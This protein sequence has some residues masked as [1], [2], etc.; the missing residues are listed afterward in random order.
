MTPTRQRRPP[1]RSAAFPF[2][3]SHCCLDLVHFTAARR[4][5]HAVPL[6]QDRKSKKPVSRN[7]D[8]PW[9]QDDNTP[10]T[11]AASTKPTVCVAA[12]RPDSST[13]QNRAPP[14]LSHS[15]NNFS[16]ERAHAPAYAAVAAA[17]LP[18]RAAKACARALHQAAGGNAEASAK[19]AQVAAILG[20]VLGAGASPIRSI[21]RSFSAHPHICTP[22]LSRCPWWRAWRPLTQPLR[23]LASPRENSCSSSIPNGSARFSR[24]RTYP[25]QGGFLRKYRRALCTIAAAKFSSHKPHSPHCRE[26]AR[27]QKRSR[28]KSR[29]R[30]RLAATAYLTD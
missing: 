19:A 10:P 3:V 12:R 2:A 21:P 18:R 15:N 9:L 25:W 24:P 23:S 28:Q 16:S 8:K 13:D 17:H 27:L 20:E 14:R 5:A 29:P 4:Q 11:P 22:P 30:P 1:P 7:Y 26:T 6:Q